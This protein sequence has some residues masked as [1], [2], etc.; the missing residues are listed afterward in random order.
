MDQEPQ[1]EVKVDEAKEVTNPVKENADISF[2]SS[3]SQSSLHRKKKT[4]DLP[5]K[6]DR[7]SRSK[8]PQSNEASEQKPKGGNRS[9]SGSRN[10]RRNDD[11]GEGSGRRHG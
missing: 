11:R 4:F 3:N 10:N 6:D 5:E 1:P 7:K 9:R 8:S 2:S